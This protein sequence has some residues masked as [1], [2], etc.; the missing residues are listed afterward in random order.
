MDHMAARLPGAELPATAL[1]QR[2]HGEN[3]QQPEADAE[4][5]SGQP[6]DSGS[7]RSSSRLTH[8]VSMSI[9]VVAQ[10]VWIA[11]LAYGAYRIGL[12]LPL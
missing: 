1:D 2:P 8:R 3:D 7:P 4:H 6:A 10:L 9:L 5:Q 11:L 12:R